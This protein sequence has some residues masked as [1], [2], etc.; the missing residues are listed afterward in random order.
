MYREFALCHDAVQ[1]YACKCWGLLAAGQGLTLLHAFA[2]LLKFEASISA[3]IV[4]ACEDM[5]S[6]LSPKSSGVPHPFT[7][8]LP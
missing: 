4:H 2:V 8:N 7:G 3:S 5:Y 1:N 6:A